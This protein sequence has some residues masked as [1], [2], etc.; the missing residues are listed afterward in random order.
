MIAARLLRTLFHWISRHLV[1]LVCIAFVATGWTW[2]ERI[3]SSQPDW[4]ELLDRHRDQTPSTPGAANHTE[5]PKGVFRPAAPGPVTRKGMS[6][7]ETRLGR[8]RRAFW[9]GRHAEAERL[10]RAEIAERPEGV[11]GYGELGNLLLELGRESEARAQYRE[12]IRRLEDSGR[13]AEADRLRALLAN[14]PEEDLPPVVRTL[15][16]DVGKEG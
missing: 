9:T 5:I 1:V 10:Y 14:L 15:G 6:D 2:R 11:D 13:Q 4:G 8:A 3:F 7:A 12:A 16:Q